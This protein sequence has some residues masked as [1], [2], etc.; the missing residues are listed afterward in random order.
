[1]CGCP[2]ERLAERS[3]WVVF[4]TFPIM[5]VSKRAPPGKI[6]GMCLMLS[7]SRKL[8]ATCVHVTTADQ[9]QEDWLVAEDLSVITG[10]HKS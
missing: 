5:K 3:S 9:A 7:S 1:M 6:L 4:Q 10:I 8:P 2:T